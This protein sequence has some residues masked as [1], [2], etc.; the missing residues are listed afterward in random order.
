MSAPDEP[1]AKDGVSGLVPELYYDLIARIA[2][3]TLFVLV[4]LYSWYGNITEA[5]GLKLT[6]FTSLLVIIGVGYIAGHLL[7]TC[8][9]M[10]SY[11]LWCP[12]ILRFMKKKLRLSYKLRADTAAELFQETYERI[13][14]VSKMDR[15]GGVIL[16]KMEAGAALADNFLCG[17][18][19]IWVFNILNPPDWGIDVRDKYCIII[20]G[21]LLF[22]LF[23]AAGSW[24]RRS[25]LIARQD[26][27]LKILGARQSE[28]ES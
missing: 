6:D 16:K 20:A 28:A 24:V 2:P 3:G 22:S 10:L 11:L 1:Q 4:A 12:C 23:L 17:W 27:L 15:S 8:S 9:A 7:Q 13:D 14:L 26:I 5:T 18:I 21:G 19:I 25:I